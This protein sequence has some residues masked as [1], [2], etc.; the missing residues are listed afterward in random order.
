VNTKRIIKKIIFI[1]LTIVSCSGL[2]VLLVA[3]IGKR[4]HERCRDYVIT[5]KGARQNLF[6]NEKDIKTMLDVAADGKIRDER[7]TD[8]NLRK[9]ELRLK[10]NAWVRDA[11]LYFD[12]KDVL[13]VSVL[14]KEPVARIFT[15][16]GKSFYIDSGVNQM[17]LSTLRSA[18]VPVFTNFPDKQLPGE[19]DSVLL[20]DIKKMALFILSDSFWMAQTEQID[21]TENKNFEMV[22]TIG[23]HT[24]KLGNG[25]DIE[26]KFHRLFVFYQQVLSKTGFDKYRTIDVQYEGQVIGTREKISKIDSLQLK[27]NV[28]KLLQEARQMQQDTVASPN[29]AAVSDQHH[30]PGTSDAKT[31]ISSVPL[32][33]KRDAKPK[34]SE[35]KSQENEPKAVMKAKE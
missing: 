4:N 3:A 34:L 29:Q 1:G 7:V 33:T 6:I 23:N 18:K 12:N 28:E 24:V 16:K 21:I 19:K 30:L 14:E 2:I 26:K 8:F 17:P 35:K 27:K 9:L 31:Q 5:I 25:S 32:K 13:H 22:P 10:E 20:N 11:N 15:T